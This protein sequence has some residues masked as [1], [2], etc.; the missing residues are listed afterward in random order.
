MTDPRSPHDVQP[1]PSAPDTEVPTPPEP[2]SDPG[3]AHPTYSAPTPQPY[4]TPYGAPSYQQ[5]AY[6]PPGYQQPG[7]QQPGYPASTYPPAPRHAVGSTA[8]LGSGES[9]LPRWTWPL[10]TFLALVVGALGG[11]LGGAA[12]VQNNDSQGSTSVYKVEPR[13]AAPLP[14]DNVSIA[15]V[16]EKLLP[17]TVQIVAE[18][19]G[20]DA[21]AVGSGFFFDLQ[22]HVITNNHVIEEAAKDAGKI[23]VIDSDGGRH[24]ASVVG[25]SSVYDLAV[26]KIEPFKGLVPAARGSADQMRVGEIVVASGS[27]LRYA[28]SITSGI[29]SAKNRPVTTGGQG[30]AASF[31]NAIQTDA[32]INPGNSG[33]PLANLQG[34]VIGVNSAL[35][36]LGGASDEA[37]NIGIGFSIPI[38]QVL[39]TADQILRTGKAQY[40]VIG[41]SVTGTEEQDGALVKEI[42]DGTPAA[43]SDLR[44]GD[45]ITKVDGIPVTDQTDVI[46]AIRSHVAGDIVKLTVRRKGETLTIPVGLIGKTG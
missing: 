13:T 1:A 19:K 8:V 20:V 34:Q 4:P 6:P 10:V 32:A 17:S 38:E 37:A 21:G 36:S 42:N 14:D 11:A 30:D 22:G 27:P 39:V 40:P 26:L 28:A 35:A 43:D 23:Q 18:Y 2:E 9:R 24:R 7:Y 44:V 33:G 12:V 25:R 41:V 45:T 5:P 31:I 29:I 15:A 3:R 16:A 46:V